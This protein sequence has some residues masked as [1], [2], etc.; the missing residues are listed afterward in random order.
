MKVYS[1]NM[2]N[3]DFIYEIDYNNDGDD[4]KLSTNDKALESMKI[5][6][7]AMEAAIVKYF[8]LDKYAVDLCKIT[9]AKD[10]DHT[11]SLKFSARSL[12][13][14]TYPMKRIN[15][16]TSITAVTEKQPSDERIAMQNCIEG[17]K[18]EVE[19]YLSGQRAQGN[20]D[21]EWV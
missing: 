13:K 21:F 16:N 11:T 10:N 15:I 2:T 7:T 8:E 3:K 14:D 18:E 6:I 19:K 12:S 4:L 5:A 20:L 1:L 9:F 17:L